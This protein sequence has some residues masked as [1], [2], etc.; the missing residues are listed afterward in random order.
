MF[1]LQI[2]ENYSL[3][4]ILLRYEQG[5]RDEET[6]YLYE[7]IQQYKMEA[8]A[9]IVFFF[10]Q[11]QE[12]NPDGSVKEFMIWVDKNV[13]DYIKGCLRNYYRGVPYDVLKRNAGSYKT[14]SQIGIQ[15]FERPKV[16]TKDY[17][18]QWT[19]LAQR[20]RESGNLIFE[21]HAHYNLENFNGFRDKLLLRMKDAGIERCIIPSIE[22]RKGSREI[23][24]EILGGFENYDWIYYAFAAHPKYLWK[25]G[26]WDSKCWEDFE[27]LLDHP[28]CIAVGETGLDYS[29]P[30]FDMEHQRLQEEFFIRFINLANMH[31]LPV[32]LH[33]R[34]GYD[35]E[36]LTDIPDVNAD[37]IR[38]LQMYPIQYGAVCHCFNGD[39]DT[40]NKYLNC[41]VKYFGIGGLILS[42]IKQFEEAVM[43]MPMEAIVLETDAPY[44]NTLPGIVGPNTSYALLPVAEKIAE[45]KKITV[46][47]VLSTTY[48]NAET[49]FHV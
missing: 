37:A 4:T 22:T 8:E 19:T 29:Y 49:L 23:N 34:Q 30:T 38:I 1:I 17:L 41:G 26:R 27:K 31:G 10:N 7:R 18:R 14:I 43:E 20:L 12:Y 28:K 3:D 25:N 16:E 44:I 47:E 32:I 15:V 13:P 42:G 21:T 46:K 39:T 5:E 6:C 40:M 35:R 36:N 9:Q 24:L 11:F 48:K 45:I 33:L 2:F